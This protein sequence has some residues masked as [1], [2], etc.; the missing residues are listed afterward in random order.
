M[1]E[2]ACRYWATGNDGNGKR[3]WKMET[4]MESIFLVMLQDNS[5]P[6]LGLRLLPRLYGREVRATARAITCYMPCR[7]VSTQRLAHGTVS[8]ISAP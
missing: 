6:S 7:S 5:I 3:K 1:A 2:A 8:E 4:E